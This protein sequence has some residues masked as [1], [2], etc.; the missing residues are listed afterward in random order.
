MI[1]VNGILEN[2]LWKKKI[3]K[4]HIFFNELTKNL[5]KKINQR[6][7]YRFHSKKNHLRKKRFI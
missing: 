1:G 4:L 6:I 2:K 7:F 3:K 5:E